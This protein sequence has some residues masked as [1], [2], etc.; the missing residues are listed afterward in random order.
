MKSLK[1]GSVAFAV[2]LAA[3]ACT[4]GAAPTGAA[5]TN[6]GDPTGSA[7]TASEPGAS[8]PTS[9]EPG[10]SEPGASEPGASQP[11]GEFGTDEIAAGEPILIGTAM[12]ITGANEALGLDSQYGAEVALS[13]RPEVVGH[14][15][16]FNHQ[17]DGCSAEGG[18][19]AARALVSDPQIVA[20]IGTSCSS[21]G[22]PAAEILSDEGVILISS[23]NTAPSLTAPDTHQDF[24]LRTAH[25]DK[26]QGE[27]MA[28]FACE[29]LEVSTAATIHDGSPY[30]QQ[31]QQVFADQFAAICDGTITAQEAINVGDTDFRPL[32]TS[33]AAD[34]PEFLYYPIFVAEGGLITSQARETAG[35]EDTLLAGSDGIFTPDFLDAAGGAA[36]DMYLS[37]PDLEYEGGFYADEF[38]PAY[39]EISGEDQPISVF[40]AHAFD[41]ANM[42]FDAIEAVAVEN[43]DGSLSIDRQALRDEIFATSGYEGVT[44]TLTCD[45]FGDCADAQISVSQVQDGEFVRI[46]PEE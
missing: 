17:D 3:V 8:A 27:A 11:A 39:S 40:H 24:Y 32:L 42:I 25:N 21:A 10:A 45:E 34:S 35:L 15:V 7:P 5:P 33:I 1:L 12:V 26:I 18:Q 14:P 44:G 6:G 28:R 16:E 13:L 41:A 38:L 29:E 22:V 30:A 43:A 37:G 4:P 20:V 19:T 46:W 31:L 9:S 23:S 2:M 36:D